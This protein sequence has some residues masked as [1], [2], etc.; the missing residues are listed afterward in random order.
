MVVQHCI[1]KEPRSSSDVMRSVS[2]LIAPA[3]SRSCTIAKLSV[4]ILEAGSFFSKRSNL[5]LLRIP[6]CASANAL[7]SATHKMDDCCSS[8]FRSPVWSFWCGPLP[9]LPLP[10]VENASTGQEM[11][12]CRYRELRPG[13]ICDSGRI[14]SWISLEMAK[15]GE[16]ILF[17]CFAESVPPASSSSFRHVTT[18][19]RRSI[20]GSSQQACCI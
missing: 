13:S 16:A 4:S 6:L 11:A 1:S 18:S 19:H 2:R 7:P 9:P 17:F 14:C 10:E 5:S 15:G 8:A 12:A 3:C 20:T